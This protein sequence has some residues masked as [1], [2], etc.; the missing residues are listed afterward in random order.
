LVPPTESLQILYN[1]YGT[2][3]RW[4]M[5]QGPQGIPV[6][7]CGDTRFKL[8]AHAVPEV[9]IPHSF[10]DPP[11]PSAGYKW[12]VSIPPLVD[13]RYESDPKGESAGSLLCGDRS[14]I[15]PF[16]S[17]PGRAEATILCQDG[18][19]KRAWYVEY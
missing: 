6:N 8:I 9:R 15:Y 19:F 2:A 10:E 1:K 14:L 18:Q 16:L 11:F 3:Y 17:D 13:C 5:Y 12:P 7:P 4:Y